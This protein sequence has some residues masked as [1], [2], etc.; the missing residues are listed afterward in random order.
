LIGAAGFISRDGV[1]DIAMPDYPKSIS[2]LLQNQVAVH[3]MT[4]E[5][6]LSKSKQAALQALLVDPID[7]K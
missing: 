4:A 5:A 3:A 7:E 1:K 6:I 2:G